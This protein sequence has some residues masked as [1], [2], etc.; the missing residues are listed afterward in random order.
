MRA[1]L[2]SRAKSHIADM[3]DYLKARGAAGTATRYSLAIRAALELLSYFPQY[4]HPGTAA[5]TYEWVV[6]ATPYI[7]VYELLGRDELMVLGV[8]HEAQD[9]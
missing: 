7:V 9:R 6:R 4:G 8:F 3:R 2:S 1:R 5:G